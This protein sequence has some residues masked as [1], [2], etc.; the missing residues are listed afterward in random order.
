MTKKIS[1]PYRPNRRK[2]RRSRITFLRDR[3]GN[4]LRDIMRSR[5]DS[6]LASGEQSLQG[7]EE[8]HPSPHQSGNRAGGNSAWRRGVWAND[9]AAAAALLDLRGGRCR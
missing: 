2:P 4:S 1:R 3:V 7:L 8:A 9:G 6:N 5:K